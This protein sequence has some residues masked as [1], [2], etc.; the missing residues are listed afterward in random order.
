M[1]T[2]VCI[3]N[4]SHFLI[5]IFFL[6]SKVVKVMGNNWITKHP[7]LIRQKKKKK[8]S[9]IEREFL[10]FACNSGDTMSLVAHVSS[11]PIGRHWCTLTYTT[12]WG[13]RE[14]V[15]VTRV[16]MLM[17]NEFWLLLVKLQPPS[18]IESQYMKAPVRCSCMPCYMRFSLY[19]IF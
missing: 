14:F 18:L 8:A 5:S 1:S 11:V 13:Q 6:I 15:R 3:I 12:I 9:T 7:Q 10:R 16:S 17:G 2:A 4:S 19:M